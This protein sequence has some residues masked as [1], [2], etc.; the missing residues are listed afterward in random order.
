M[1]METTLTVVSRDQWRTWLKKHHAR[2][3]EVWLVFFKKAAGRRGIGYEDA[4]DEA[5]C[6]GWID[7][8]VQRIDAER[9]ARKF[10]PRKPG[11]KWSDINKQRVARLI[12]TGRMTEA[13]RSKVAF[14]RKGEPQNRVFKLPAS[15]LRQ[16]RSNRRAS[17]NFKA[18]A[19]SYQRLY[20]GWILDA[21]R[22]DTRIRRMRE[23]I[24]LLEKSKKLGL[25]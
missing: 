9:Y 24:G 5:L 18:L 6:F 8:L 11:S 14:P 21:K 3:T 20:I 19:P 22:D 12:E 13:G 15:L 25:K 1:K 2:K 4:V 16:L 23:A 7:S 17:G 10:T